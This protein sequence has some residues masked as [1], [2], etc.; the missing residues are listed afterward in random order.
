MGRRVSSF[1]L[2]LVFAIWSVLVPVS[3]SAAVFNASSN[4]TG[5]AWYVPAA[6]TGLAGNA[7]VATAATLLGRANPWVAALTIGTP[8]MQILLESKSGGNVAVVAKD[9]LQPTPPGWA[10]S[11]HPPATAATTGTG[12]VP[13]SAS[14][15]P[16]VTY[17]QINTCGLA[18]GCTEYA[19][20]AAARAAMLAAYPSC[21]TYSEEPA[22][23]GAV[24]SNGSDYTWAGFT[25]SG[26]VLSSTYKTIRYHAR[27]ASGVLQGSPG[28]Y[29]CSGPAYSCPTG[30]TL[31]GSN[32]VD[33]PQ[34]PAGYSNVSGTCTLTDGAA[35]KWPSDGKATLRLDGLGIGL[36][37]RDPDLL[38]GT[39]TPADVL[40]PARDYSPDPYNQPASSSIT[41]NADGGYTWNQSVQ[42]TN[43]MQTYTTNNQITV[44]NLGEVTH[45]VTNTVAG[46]IAQGGTTP[47][48]PFPDDYNRE[49]TQAKILTGEGAMD[50]PD[51]AAQLAAKTATEEGKLTDKL[52]TY[53]GEFA[54]DKTKWFSWVWTPPVGTCA[55]ITGEVRGQQVS[56]DFCP[57]VA[58]I[59]DVMGYLFA[60]FG[61]WSVY[62]E[63]FRKES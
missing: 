52:N 17:G 61:A 31:S 30:G 32:C 25:G 38:P 37:P 5:R 33:V 46:G 50:A 62:N 24:M 42:T 3:V 1:V 34:C 13:A 16:N 22:F 7:V 36:H 15:S 60:I 10:D 19:T 39:L 29:T 51:Y 47:A 57:Y 18:M 63:L 45:A 14:Y 8:I 43:N 44:N 58:K 41:P 20:V 53:P 21:S 6:G 11:E 2:A 40:N 35:V 56:W 23:A 59:R 48:Q 49:V 55:P 27:C 54:S 12:T 26:C 4:L 9:S 28:A